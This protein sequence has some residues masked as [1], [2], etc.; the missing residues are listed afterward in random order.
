MFTTS[1]AEAPPSLVVL[2][3]QARPDQERLSDIGDR[4]TWQAKQSGEDIEASCTIGQCLEILLFSRAEAKAIHVFQRTRFPQLIER[5]GLLATAAA[6][7]AA[8][9]QD[10]ERYILRS[11]RMGTARIRRCRGFGRM[12]TK[13]PWWPQP[14]GGLLDRA[15]LVRDYGVTT[16]TVL[17]RTS[18]L[19]T[20]PSHLL[21]CVICIQLL[22][23]HAKRI[24]PDVFRLVPHGGIHDSFKLISQFT[25]FGHPL[26]VAHR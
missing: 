11:S 4:S 12:G 14:P 13:T 25:S 1:S 24:Q 15:S 18:E 17:S 8:T 26:C 9:L 19:N 10:P 5:D 21:S 6:K 23:S 2:D 3:D 7:T 16:P 20:S 22:E